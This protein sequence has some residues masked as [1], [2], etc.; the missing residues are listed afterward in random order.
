MQTIYAWKDDRIIYK[1]YEEQKA[2]IRMVTGQ[3]WATTQAWILE[4][5]HDPRIVFGP[6]LSKYIPKCYESRFSG[7]IRQLSTTFMKITLSKSVDKIV[8]N[9]LQSVGVI[10]GRCLTLLEYFGHN[11][12]NTTPNHLIQVAMES[13]FNPLQLSCWWFYQILC[14]IVKN[15]FII[16]KWLVAYP[17]LICHSLNN[18]PPICL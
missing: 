15:V 4:D 17:W 10:G 13:W 14:I 1:F 6:Y 9:A 11:F 7:K 3:M 8:K 5:L 12:L 16:G 18:P 2:Q